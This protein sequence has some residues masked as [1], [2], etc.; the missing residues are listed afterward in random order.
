VT[1]QT[2]SPASI[3]ELVSAGL[4]VAL[5]A[6]SVARAAGPPVE[7]HPLESTIAHPP[8]AVITAAREQLPPAP[9]EFVSYLLRGL[10]SD[11]TASPGEH[12]ERLDA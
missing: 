2:Y 7:T 5:L 10:P 12:A 3:R 4:G 11:A 6:G 8:I 1:F 9:R